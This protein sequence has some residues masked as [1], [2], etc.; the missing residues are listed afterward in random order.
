[1]SDSVPTRLR[2]PWDSPGK[3]TGVGYHFLLQSM[4]VKSESEVAQLCLSLCDPM[5]CSLP[6]SSIHGIFQARVLEWGA[7]CIYMEFRKMVM[8]TLYLR[9][10]KR[11][12]CIEQSFGLWEKVTVGWF[13]RIA[14]K[15]IYYHMWNRSPVQVKCMRQGA[16]GWCTGM[17]Q[18]DGMG[19]E[20]GEGFRTGDTCTPM[21]D[22][23][24]CMAKATTIL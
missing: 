17:T 11:H 18:R 12:R 20:V 2:C 21:A 1:M 7:Q 24:K 13:E 14:L 5:D 4:K 6:G 23:C 15:H 19:R 10:Q 22:S 16:Q 8:I 9:Q 3:S